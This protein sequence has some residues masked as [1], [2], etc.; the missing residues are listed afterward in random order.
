ME[1]S[2]SLIHRGA[3]QRKGRQC[4]AR[5]YP[6][7]WHARSLRLRG[8]SIIFPMSPASF[9]FHLQTFDWKFHSR[10]ARMTF[11]LMFVPGRRAFWMSFA[12]DLRL[13]ELTAEQ[14]SEPLNVVDQDERDLA[15]H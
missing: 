4:F 10:F 13:R 6:D 5:D 12:K 3:L 15:G 1:V 14:F 9:W 7:N 2:F 8:S 11:R